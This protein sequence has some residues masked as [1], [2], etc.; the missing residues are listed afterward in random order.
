MRKKDKITSIDTIAK[1]VRDACEG[2]FKGYQQYLPLQ[3]YD[4][5]ENK[6]SKI[7]V[8]NS[9]LSPMIYLKQVANNLILKK[10]SELV[11]NGDI[12]LEIYLIDQYSSL[13]RTTMLKMGHSM[14]EYQQYGETILMNAIETYNGEISFGVYLVQCIR[15][16]KVKDDTPSETIAMAKEL[17]LDD[18]ISAFLKENPISSRKPD[19]I[20]GLFHQLNGIEKIATQDIERNEFLYV[21]YGYYKE[22]YFTLEEASVI[23]RQDKK[24]LQEYYKESLLQLKEII[25]KYIDEISVN[26]LQSD[27]KQYYI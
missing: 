24:V 18:R 22:I 21:K 14:I 10:L 12:D 7:D 25:S 8:S 5:L 3:F 23:L 16:F 1:Q 26:S 2:Q 4:D 19:Y 11:R 27:S 9:G 20:D 17:S 6:L 15:G 13:L